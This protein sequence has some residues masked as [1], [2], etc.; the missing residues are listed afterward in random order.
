MER[1]S[2]GT[3]TDRPGA[4]GQGALDS[5]RATRLPLAAP[6]RRG[7]S[8][9]ARLR[10]ETP[11]M[12]VAADRTRLAFHRPLRPVARRRPHPTKLGRTVIRGSRHFCSDATAGRSSGH[13]SRAD[14]VEVAGGSERRS[15]QSGDREE[16]GTSH[17][18]LAQGE[19]PDG[20][21]GRRARGSRACD[22][23]VPVVRLPGLR[24][25]W[26]DGVRSGARERR[27]GDQRLIA[28]LGTSDMSSVPSP[29]TARPC[30]SGVVP[31]SRRRHHAATSRGTA[32]Q[33]ESRSAISREELGVDFSLLVIT[34]VSRIRVAQA[35]D[36]PEPLFD[37]RGGVEPDARAVR[38]PRRV[39]SV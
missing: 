4:R 32:R 8:S 2:P 18:P 22:G 37:P 34:E 12:G 23:A 38:W 11:P 13:G 16:G 36:E 17:R 29:R 5:R 7:N 21:S 28:V 10:P 6:G 20:A 33:T 30:A 15:L 25:K 3:R 14:R 26:E 24:A 27:A 39:S 35:V 31:A 9:P 19:S 1:V